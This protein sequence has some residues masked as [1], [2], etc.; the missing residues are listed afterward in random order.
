MASIQTVTGEVAAGDLG[1][2]L[3][4]EH[5]AASSAGIL[6]SWPQLYGSYAGLVTRGT[7]A[8]RAA[9][10]VG[11]K[12]IVDCTTFD[13]GRDAPLLVDVASKSG[14][15]IIAATGLWL[16]P[17]ATLRSR[18]AA[19]LA[20]Q[21][22]LDLTEGMDGTSIRAGVIKVASDERV[23]PFAALILEAAA[24]ACRETSAPIITHTSATHRTGEQQ[25]ELLEKHGVD[26]TRVAIGHSDDSREP[27]YLCGLA[28]RG[29]YIAMDRLPNG[30]LSE[31]GGQ[32]VDDRMDM[33]ALLV[34]QGHGSRVLLS[35][36]DPV[37]AGL[38]TDEDQ[39]RHKAANPKQLAFVSEVV[40]PGLS[41]R[42]VPAADITQMTI[43]NPKNWLAGS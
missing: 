30:A 12:T 25:A 1:F 20:D 16:D 43:E 29:Y 17:P 13:L 5:V 11:V 37:W 41:A 35:H 2:V 9:K 10:A 40:L 4:H 24:R 38:L 36:D 33:I 42:G 22:V 15:T 19:Q 27:D 21:F 32:T 26:P 39:A 8:L 23:E 18:T 34:E 3:V 28:E 31:Y 7:L 14:V 6:S